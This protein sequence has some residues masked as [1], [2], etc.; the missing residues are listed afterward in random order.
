M[1]ETKFRGKRIENG[2]WVIGY[3]FLWEHFNGKC[4]ETVHAIDV[5]GAS[6]YLVYSESIGQST[7]LSD[8]NGKNIFEGDVLGELV[9]IDGVNE[10]SAWPV[11]WSDDHAAFMVDLSFSKNRRYLELL[12]EN[13]KGLE[14]IGNLFERNYELSKP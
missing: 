11:V 6:R 9:E 2:E 8:K 12:S 10:M 1:R 3:Y 13:Y 14:I 4:F 7:G 5:E